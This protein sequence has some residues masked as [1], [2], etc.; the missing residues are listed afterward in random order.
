MSEMEMYCNTGV[1]EWLEDRSSFGLFT[2]DPR[3]VVTGWNNWLE[4]HSGRTRQKVMG[5]SLL[6]LYPDL[7]TR[8]MDRYFEEALEGRP[9]SLSQAFH[10]Y[11]LPIKCGDKESSDTIMAQSAIISPHFTA[12]QNNHALCVYHQAL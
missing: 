9:A 7:V 1:A 11:L 5:K 12:G 2:T 10:G 6:D 8:K 4:S 3:L